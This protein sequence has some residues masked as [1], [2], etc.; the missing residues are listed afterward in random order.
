M[1][2]VQLELVNIGGQY[3]LGIV[4]GSERIVLTL[5]ATDA[6]EAEAYLDYVRETL[7]STAENEVI[8]CPSKAL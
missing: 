2:P 7:S 8:V 1:E 5:T 3:F 4:K 6:Q